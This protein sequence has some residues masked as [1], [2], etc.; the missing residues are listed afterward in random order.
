MESEAA[1]ALFVA[2]T[3]PMIVFGALHALGTLLDTRRPTFFTPVDDSVREQTHGTGIRLLPLVGGTSEPRPSMWRV[4]LGINVSHGL[5]IA[6]FGLLCLLIAVEDASLV[7]RV[8]G[9]QVL[10]IAF[11]AM[12]LVLSVRFWF[13]GP[14]LI[15]STS[16]A[17][18]TAAAL[19]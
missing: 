8:G 5:G 16:T 15:T 1:Q 7:E 3:V 6:F 13:W 9:L 19:V 4:W 12:L 17:C 11:P 14:V 10:T 18:F 2:G